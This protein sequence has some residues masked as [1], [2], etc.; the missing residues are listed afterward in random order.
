MEH[1]IV[2][3]KT[4][5]LSL[6]FPFDR[7]GNNL[8]LA[9]EAKEKDPQISD[10]DLRSLKKPYPNLN[11]TNGQAL[12]PVVPTADEPW[13]IEMVKKTHA[14]KE[15]DIWILPDSH[16]DALRAKS[17]EASF[18]FPRD[19][20]EKSKHY[21]QMIEDLKVPFKLKK[22]SFSSD[23]ER[24]DSNYM[25][26]ELFHKKLMAVHKDFRIVNM[27]VPDVMKE[28]L[29]ASLAILE[30]S[31]MQTFFFLKRNWPKG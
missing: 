23:Q 8:L 29:E 2:L 15:K 10:E 9:N 18:V 21:N 22:A 28:D 11:F 1:Y 30:G 3:S 14:F 16:L 27:A 13:D 20:Q 24:L 17:G 26:F 5:G 25:E 4:D 7:F 6:C 19:Y 12:V 31:R